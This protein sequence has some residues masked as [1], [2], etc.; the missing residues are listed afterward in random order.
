[1]LVLPQESADKIPT[2]IDMERPSTWPLKRNDHK[3]T[4]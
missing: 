4:F 1:V 2:L 3:R